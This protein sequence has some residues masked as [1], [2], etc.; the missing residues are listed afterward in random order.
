MLTWVPFSIPFPILIG[1]EVDIG[2][3]VDTLYIPLK[4]KL[5]LFA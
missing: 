3:L 5:A 1:K 4:L 2:A